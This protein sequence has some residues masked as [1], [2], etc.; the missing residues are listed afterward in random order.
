MPS[1][2]AIKIKR[3]GENNITINHC[4]GGGDCGGGR[5]S[6]SS[7]DCDGSGNGNGKGSRDNDNKGGDNRGG[8]AAAMPRALK[9]MAVVRRR[10]K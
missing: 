3:G 2:G 9:A 5:K 1:I 4:C 6:D 7:S 8:G 10:Q